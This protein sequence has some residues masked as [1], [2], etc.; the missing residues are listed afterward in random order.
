ML[1]KTAQVMENTPHMQDIVNGTM[2]MEKF[3]FQIM[4]NYQYL[5]DYLRTLS[6]ALAKV[7]D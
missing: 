6:T 2:P 1:R 3:R 4:Q 5:M 7:E